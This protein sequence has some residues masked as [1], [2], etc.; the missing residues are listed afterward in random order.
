MFVL[1]L[2]AWSLKI[3]FFFYFFPVTKLFFSY[4][5]ISVAIMWYVTLI[6]FVFRIF[7]GV[8]FLFSY[9]RSNFFFVDIYDFRVLWGFL[10]FM[11]RAYWNGVFLSTVYMLK[12]GGSHFLFYL[13]VLK[14]LRG[15]LCFVDVLWLQ[16]KVC[17]FF[18]LYFITWKGKIF[19]L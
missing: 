5:G 17:F 7:V 4:L 15:S 6:W 8:S 1:F 9:L 10:V 19:G 3:R 11:Y 13:E 14:V 16:S 12:S 2:K 18:F